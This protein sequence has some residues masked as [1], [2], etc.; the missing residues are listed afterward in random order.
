MAKKGL[1]GMEAKF[2]ERLARH[3]QP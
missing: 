1:R 2:K 3:F